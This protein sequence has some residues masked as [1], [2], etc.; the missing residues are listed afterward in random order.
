[1]KANT[2]A[3]PDRLRRRLTL[4]CLIAALALLPFL[5]ACGDTEADADLPHGARDNSKEVE[6]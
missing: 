2:H 6:D 1:M 4:L 3:S 5:A